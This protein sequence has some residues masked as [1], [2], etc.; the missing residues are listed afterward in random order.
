MAERPD[1][2]QDVRRHGGA[3]GMPGE[4][5]R[6][7][8]NA[9]SVV[10]L[11]EQR[12]AEY[13]GAP[14]AVAVDCATSALFLCCKYLRVEEVIL[15]ARTY[16]SVPAYVIHAGGRVRFEDYEWH[17]VYQIRP[18]PLWDCSKRFRRGMFAAL[19]HPPHEH[20]Y[21]V[22]SFHS[23]KILNIGRGGMVLTD[24]ATA[25]AWLRRA[26]YDGREGKPYAQENVGELGYHVYMTPDAA[27]RG[28]QLLDVL[29]E[30]MPD[31]EEDYPDLREM[32][33]FRDQAKGKAA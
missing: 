31:Q 7:S 12:I 18:L 5:V 28:L 33:V 32:A 3:L 10:A 20:L 13:T 9:F 26:R 4:A 1:R 25:A 14:H 22:L 24:D 17:G 30:G 8:T 15:P 27:A 16:I 19:P 2:E 11:F 6:P 23:K 21:A 29:P